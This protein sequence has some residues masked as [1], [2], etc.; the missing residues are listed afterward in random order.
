MN[1]SFTGL[2]NIGAASNINA[3][4]DN[5]FKGEPEIMNRLV[6]QLTDIGTKDLQE[7]QTVLKK[8]PDL[9]TKNNFLRIDMHSKSNVEEIINLL[10]NPKTVAK[11]LNLSGDIFELNGKPIDLYEDASVFSKIVKL[12]KRIVNEKEE[13]PISKDY[14]ESED[15]LINLQSGIAPEMEGREASVQI[16]PIEKLHGKDN[17]QM[18]A[19][20][21]EQGI[22]NAMERFY[23]N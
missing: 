5:I 16:F 23:S 3:F 13:F 1:V 12:V 7:F 10:N 6:V 9:K 8:F 18:I 11:N 22:N 2:Q 4:R 14:L 21:I 19:Q 20:K 15:A 17:V